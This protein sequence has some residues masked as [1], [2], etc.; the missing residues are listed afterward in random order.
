M[1][2]D[3]FAFLGV[4]EA[5]FLFQ[6]GD[7]AFDGAGEVIQH[8]GVVLATC[9]EDG[10]FVDEVGQ[11]RTG[12]SGGERGDFFHVDV[13]AEA[14]FFQVDAQYL[15]TAGLV[16]TIDEDLPVEAPCPQQ[17]RVEDFRPVGR[18]QQHQSGAGVEAVEFGEELVERLFLFVVSADAVGAACLAQRVDFV[19]EDDGGRLFSGLFEQIAH[20]CRTDAD[21]HFD[22]FGAVDGEER[23]A[24]FTGDGLGKQ[25]FAGSRR[26]DEQYAVGNASAQP[27]VFFRIAQKADDFL[28]FFFRFID[29]GDVVEGDLDVFFDIDFGAAFADGEKAAAAA[30]AGLPCHA[31]HQEH[32]DAEEDD[33]RNDPAEDVGQ[34]GILDD[35]GEAHVMGGKLVRQRVVHPGGGK[36]GFAVDGFPEDAADFVAD[37]FDLFDV[38]VV[39]LL[40]KGA[41]WQG[42]ARLVVRPESACQQYADHGKHDVPHQPPVALGIVVIHGVLLS[43]WQDRMAW[44]GLPSLQHNA[45]ALLRLD[46]G[47]W[48]L[49]SG[50]WRAVSAVVSPAL[51]CRMACRRAFILTESAVSCRAPPDNPPCRRCMSHCP[52][53]RILT[54]GQLRALPGERRQ[55]C[56]LPAGWRPR[57]SGGSVLRRAVRASVRAYDG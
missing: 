38:A 37:D 20:A 30:H 48:R 15:D 52:V 33:G 27:S 47:Q 53:A 14:D 26:P 25:G 44:D 41:V 46:T 2:G 40:E 3:D 18:A 1:P 29:A 11:I 8:D 17:C 12:K 7:H 57:G 22:E 39:E 32:P 35:A 49:P 9:G 43:S 6:P 51:A 50:G 19:D 23:D 16:G 31:A 55:V 13:V 24:C 28:Q 45:V 34:E 4:D 54:G 10:G 42:F 56:P 36:F 5:V 21:E